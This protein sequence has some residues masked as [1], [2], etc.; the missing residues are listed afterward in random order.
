[1]DILDIKKVL[2]N[3]TSWWYHKTKRMLEI[4]DNCED[5]DTV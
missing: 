2:E 5:V 1:M 3:G 4:Q